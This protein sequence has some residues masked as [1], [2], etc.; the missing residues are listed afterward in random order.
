MSEPDTSGRSPD[1]QQS[2]LCQRSHSAPL[3]LSKPTEGE[4]EDKDHVE[5][6]EES[7]DT[8]VVE[9]RVGS[10]S[11]EEPSNRWGV[12][13]ETAAEP[14][15]P[16]LDPAE[17]D[18]RLQSSVLQYPKDPAGPDDQVQYPTLPDLGSAAASPE[19]DDIS[20]T[21]LRNTYDHLVQLHRIATRLLES[22]ADLLE[23]KQPRTS[24]HGSPGDSDKTTP[25]SGSPSRGRQREH[26]ERPQP[27][28]QSRTSDRLSGPSDH[29][30]KSPK[31]HLT[32]LDPQSRSSG[33]QSNL[34]LLLGS[35]TPSK[36][37]RSEDPLDSLFSLQNLLSGKPL[38]RTNLEDLLH[39]PGPFPTEPPIP[40]EPLYF[41]QPVSSDQKGKQVLRE[42][43]ADHAS[44]DLEA[45]FVDSKS[46]INSRMKG[47]LEAFGPQSP[48]VLQQSAEWSL[49]PRL[50]L[51]GSGPLSTYSAFPF[52]TA[53][54]GSTGDTRK[55]VGGVKEE[56]S[57]DDTD[58]GIFV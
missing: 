25:F 12:W 31:D 21:W 29:Q 2:M 50:G 30:S 4:D 54:L 18:R 10:N 20:Y 46:D 55:V 15:Y 6:E 28:D 16:S 13:P 24:R 11:P 40:M 39:L 47:V 32:S 35:S 43:V 33:H 23:S 19:P 8:N 14:E 7:T 34:P 41:Q 56:D 42:P 5:A 57:T 26:K 37:P 51:I 9:G 17:A 48:R 49:L 38:R 1:R 53:N 45:A 58:E 22:T 36:T 44:S 52:S 3:H 27:S